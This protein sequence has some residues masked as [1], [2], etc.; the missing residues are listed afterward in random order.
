MGLLD[1]FM[2]AEKQLQRHTRRL[3]NRDSQPEDREASARFLAEKGTPQAMLGLLS[4]FDMSLEHQL[5]DAGEKELVYSLLVSQGD[6]AIEPTKVWLRQCKQ[7]ALP[8]RLLGELGGTE[9]ALVGAFELLELEHRKDDFKAAKKKGLLVWLIDQR[10]PRVVAAAAPFLADF[11]E[12]VRY[13]AAEA[14][15]AQGGELARVALSPVLVNAAEESNR[16]RMRIA[17]IFA[18]RG[19]AVEGSPEGAEL[20]SGFRI[21][22]GRVATA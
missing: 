16:L 2:G 6:K 21:R 19:W 20:P 7:F 14:I 4:R 8:L 11:D 5:K 10:D 9:S 12:G 13:S 1:F 22:D 3:T 18:Q 15:I 17:A